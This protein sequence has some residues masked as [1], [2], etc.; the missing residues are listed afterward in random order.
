MNKRDRNDCSCRIRHEES[1]INVKKRDKNQRGFRL[2][3]DEGKKWPV[4]F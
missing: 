3:Q 1:E 4:T 2:R